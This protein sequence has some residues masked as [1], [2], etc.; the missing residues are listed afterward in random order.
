MAASVLNEISEHP[1]AAPDGGSAGTTADL[2]IFDPLGILFFMWDAPVRLFAVTLQGADW[3]NRASITLPHRELQNNGQWFVLKIPVGLDRTRV[4]VRSG[5]G[6]QVGLSQRLG[7][8]HAL[9]VGVGTDTKARHI[10]PVTHQETIEFTRAAGGIYLDRN[11]SLLANVIY[12]PGKN[13]LVLNVYP[14][15]LPGVAGEAGVWGVVTEERRFRFGVNFRRTLGMG[16][17]YGAH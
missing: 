1:G 14:G 15:V 7:G 5:V 4:F 16:L 13:R 11:N 2:L 17:G 8:E 12:S 9:S 3:V 6:A 10:D